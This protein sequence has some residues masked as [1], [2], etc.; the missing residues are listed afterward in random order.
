MERETA[1]ETRQL[2]EE[3]YRVEKQAEALRN[4]MIQKSSASKAPAG[5]APATRL[6][7]VP[8]NWPKDVPLPPIP[9]P[10][11]SQT[12]PATP[13]ARSRSPTDHAKAASLA[14]Q[15][16]KVAGAAAENDPKAY[17]RARLQA[18][19]AA[20]QVDGS[21]LSEPR[22]ERLKEGPV[23]TKAMPRLPTL[24]PKPKVPSVPSPPKAP[25]SPAPA[26]GV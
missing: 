18:A 22:A 5:K 17:L 7:V 9:P 15:V 12:T 24:P 26:V 16:L 10:V 4:A 13:P 3:L 6:Y 23:A 2:A 19:T 20:A 11:P 8:P 25:G 14:D 1:E 21:E